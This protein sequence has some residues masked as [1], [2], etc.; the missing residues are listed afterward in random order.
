MIM[1]MMTVTLPIYRKKYR[2]MQSETNLSKTA[3]E[4]AYKATANS[5]QAE[6]YDAIQLYQDAERRIKLY[7]HQ[8]VLAKKSL[9]II[10]ASFSASGAD[11][12]DILRIRQQTLDFEFKQVEAV[13][14]F[15][16]AIAW[17][18]RLGNLEMQ[19]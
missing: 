5:L 15:N 13:V 9:D 3:T 18:K 1:P 17:L 12:T 7:E 19:N 16:T 4:Q 14:D 11:L 6:Y 8:S 2:A 10:T